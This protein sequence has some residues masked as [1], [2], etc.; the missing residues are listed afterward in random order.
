[1]AHLV[2]DKKKLL[3]RLARIRGQLSAIERAIRD[4]E[5]SCES[6]LRTIAATRGAMS[7]LMAE[8]I[9]GHVRS[10]LLDP[11]TRPT[12]AQAAAAQ[13]LLDVIHSYLR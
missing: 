9:E 4:E 6:V 3:N 7:G 13:E 8:V 11:D 1:M 10:H 12:S 2:R 5:E